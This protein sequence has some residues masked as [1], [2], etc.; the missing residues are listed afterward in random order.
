MEDEIRH[1]KDK[2]AVKN[3]GPLMDKRQDKVFAKFRSDLANGCINPSWK[4]FLPTRVNV[5]CNGGG[6]YIVTT[7]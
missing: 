5:K 6:Y 4:K 7:L 3:F 1:K 2:S